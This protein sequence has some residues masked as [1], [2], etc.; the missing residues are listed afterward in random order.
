MKYDSVYGMW[1]LNNKIYRESGFF[2]N[3]RALND[4]A[5]SLKIEIEII[6]EEME[7]G[8]SIEIIFFC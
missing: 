1:R 7:N 4:L 8:R 3:A 6:N 2:C 5:I